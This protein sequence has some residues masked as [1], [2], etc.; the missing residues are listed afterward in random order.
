M[1]TYV[2]LLIEI[3]CILKIQ[4]LFQLLLYVV[5]NLREDTYHRKLIKLTVIINSHKAGLHLGFRTRGVK[6]TV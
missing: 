5:K 4:L 2:L 6:T 1:F 3:V